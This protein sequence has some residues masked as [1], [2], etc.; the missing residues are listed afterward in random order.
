MSSPARRHRLRVL[1]AKSAANT[2]DEFGGVRDDASVYMLQLAELKN[3]QNL[4]RNVKSE[5]ER[6]EHKATLI[7]KYMPYV[8]GVL[9]VEDRVPNL[10]D[11][12]VT[13][14]M[15]WC[16]DAKQFEDG[17]RIAE[18][19]LKHELSMPDTFSRDT[20]SIVAEEIG[21]AAKAAHA[22]G[23]VFELTVLKQA[24]S[25]TTGFSM[26]DQIRAKLYVAIGRVYLQKEIYTEAV[27]WLKLAI[28]HNEN[29]G[30]KQDLQRAER[31]LKK[32]LEENPP[33][34]LF[35][36]DGSPVVDD[37]GNQVYEGI[38]S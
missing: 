35:N 21:N 38:S 26:H 29:C 18:Y 1:A 25:I 5:I 7:P 19:A 34:P 28:K 11:H 23:D 2:Q 15:L 27:Y 33:Q 8:N 20:A 12:V 4:L 10:Q 37:Y 3:D 24:I 22:E 32:Q 14:I 30:G 9:S 6:G 16:F 17:L 36:T 31:L 13:T